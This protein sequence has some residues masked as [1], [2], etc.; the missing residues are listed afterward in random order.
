MVDIATRTGAWDA[1]DEW[2]IRCLQVVDDPKRRLDRLTP[3][4]HEMVAWGL[5]RQADDGA[6]VLPEDVQERLTH[7]TMQRPARTA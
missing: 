3:L 7:L 1:G 6:F 2:E 4:L 5:V